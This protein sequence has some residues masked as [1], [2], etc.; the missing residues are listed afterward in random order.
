MLV[1]FHHERPFILFYVFAHQYLP[2]SKTD[3]SN[4]KYYGRGECVCKMGVI[5]F[6]FNMTQ[7]WKCSWPPPHKQTNKQTPQTAELFKPVDNSVRVGGST[8]RRGKGNPNW[9]LWLC[10][11]LLKPDPWRDSDRL[12]PAVP[13]K[14]YRRAMDSCWVFCLRFMAH[15]SLRKVTLLI[16]WLHAQL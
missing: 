4:P 9:H 7:N 16:P 15:L 2:G 13:L 11:L 3:K 1:A 5:K 14:C 6:S 8:Y 12:Q 10:A